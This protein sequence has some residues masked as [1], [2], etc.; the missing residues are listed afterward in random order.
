MTYKT[1]IIRS[2]LWYNESKKTVK[3]ML[4]GLNKTELP[5]KLHRKIF[6]KSILKHVQKI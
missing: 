1:T 3:Y 5:K 4:N 6:I 2:A